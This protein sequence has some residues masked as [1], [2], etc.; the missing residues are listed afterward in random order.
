MKRRRPALFFGYWLDPTTG[1][2]WRVKRDEMRE[3]WRLWS[4]HRDI[5]EGHVQARLA[6]IAARDGR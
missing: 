3:V 1:E 2:K 5:R 4:R 6:A